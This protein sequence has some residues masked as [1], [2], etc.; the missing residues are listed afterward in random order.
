[1]ARMQAVP[2]KL[3]ERAII[4]AIP[5]AWYLSNQEIDVQKHFFCR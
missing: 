5:D 3:T 1:M 2:G 4:P